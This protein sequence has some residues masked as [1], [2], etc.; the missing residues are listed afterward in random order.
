MIHFGTDGWRALIA[1]EFTFA[2]VKIVAQAIS[3][4]LRSLYASGREEITV[5]VGYDARFLSR[6]FARTTA[7]VLA[8]NGMRAILSSGYIPSPLVSFVTRERK[9]RLG[10]MIT[11]SH[12]PYQFNGLKIKTPDGGAADTAIT[13]AV[14]QWFSKTEPKELLFEDAVNKKLVGVEDFSAGYLA[15][16]RQF[17][18]SAALKTLKVRVLVDLMY[19]SGG[20]YLARVLAGTAVNIEY[21]HGEFNPSFG[22]RNPEPLPETL[23]ELIQA[24]KRGTYE[25]GV[26]LDGDGDRVAL[27]TPQG[28]FISAQVILPLLSQHMIQNRRETGG[29]AKT[30]VGSNVIDRVAHSLKVELFETAVGFKYISNLFKQGAIAI[31]GEEAGGLGYKGFIPERDGNMSALLVLEMMGMTGKSFSSLVQSLWGTYG[32]WYYDKIKISVKHKRLNL[33][34]LTIPDTLFGEAVLSVNRVD[35][36]KVITPESWLMFRQS[37]T[38]PIVRIYA[39]SMSSEKTA[40][41]LALGKEMVE[42]LL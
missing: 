14:E 9:C 12:N 1:D 28:E 29:I 31:G 21:M 39:E 36:I 13:G 8:A 40:Q 15:F 10:I 33:A 2:N 32:K 38:E 16:L 19:G 20:E 37:G 24:M 30:V 22:G 7:C 17:V 3:D 4:Y 25:L 26:A 41:L 34:A 42:A 27:V 11:A 5:A 23:P 35:G 6:E 18:D